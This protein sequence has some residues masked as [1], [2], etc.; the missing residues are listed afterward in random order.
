MRRGTLILLIFII[1]LAAGASFVNFWPNPDTQGKPWHG[2]TNPFSVSQ[3]V[4]LAG[5]LR[6]LLAPKSGQPIPTDDEMQNTL[7]I[8]QSRL[9]GGLGVKELDIRLLHTQN[10]PTISIEMPSFSGDEQQTINNLLKTGKLEF[11]DTGPNG[12]LQQGATLDP[13]QYTQYNPGGKPLFTGHDLDPAQLGVSQAQSGGTGYDIDFA[14]QGSAVAKLSSYTAQNIGHALT[15]TLDRQVISSPTIQSQIPGNGQIT[16]NFT[17]SDAE[18]L[19]N[20]LKYGALPVALTLNSSN[21]ISPTLGETAIQKSLLAGGIGI[22]IV[23]LFML[24]YYRLPGLLADIALILYASLTFA[25]FKLIGVTM[26][27]AGIAGFILS[28]GM[29]VDANVL[30]FE[31]VK[32]EIRAGRLL[33]SAIDIGWSRAWPSIRDSNCSTLITCAVLFAFGSNFGASII[34]G[35]ASTLFLGVVVSMFTAIVATRTLLNLLVP[36][37]F[38]NHPALFG[39]PASLVPATSLARRNSVA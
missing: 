30:I 14:M 11:W 3:G 18:N 36:T 20:V 32:E 28:I 19:V 33:A 17:Y 16:G 12:N 22:G 26:S 8:V 13:T 29:A 5:G 2:I 37:G 25:V 38:I 10:I 31:R 9:S 27:L 15:I 1:L 7:Q 24:F 6:L 21:D 39:L 23:I 4:D 34:I 35:F